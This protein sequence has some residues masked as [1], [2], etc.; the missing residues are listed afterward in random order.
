MAQSTD[1]ASSTCVRRLVH[2]AHSWL[3]FRIP[4]L[5]AV[6][7]VT[8]ISL[9]VDEA[10]EAALRVG[11]EGVL[12]PVRFGCGTDEEVASIVERAVLVRHV[13]D[14][15][16]NG[17][18]WDELKASFASCAGEKA[19]PF[20]SKGATYRVR[21]QAFGL[22]YSEAEQ[23]DLIKSLVTLLPPHY[24]RVRLKQPQHR[25][26][27][28]VEAVAEAGQRTVRFSFGRV[29]ARGAR[30]LVVKYDLKQRNYIGTTS[31]DAEVA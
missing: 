29:V 25:L 13:I 10:D 28:I 18:T 23:L 21:V 12:L 24:A 7:A 31:L 26:L 14:E 15:W 4:E 19:A 6:A 11:S 8:N 30:D 22:S 5:R 17:S 20:L 3:D 2:F 16:A 9:S 1:A 27:L